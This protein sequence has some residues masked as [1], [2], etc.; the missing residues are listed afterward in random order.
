MTLQRY[1]APLFALALSAAPAVRAKQGRTLF[2]DSIRAV[3]AAPGNGPYVSSQA[4]LPGQSAATMVFSVSLKMRDLAGLQARLAAGQFVSQAEM[5]STYLPLASD[6]NRVA[7]WLT[8]QGLTTV[9]TDRNHTVL[10][11]EGTVSQVAQ[12]LGVTFSRVAVPDSA[13]SATEYTSAV[14]AP[15]LPSDLA[16]VVLGIN[17]LQPHLRFHH[18]PVT[19]LARARPQD[20]VGTGDYITPD[21]LASAY[22]MPVAWSTTAGSGQIIAIV[23][24]S[25]SP[26]ATQLN[27][28]NS[29]WSTVGSA[30]NT[31][32][33]A[34]VKV[35]GGGNNSSSDSETALDVEWAG[36]L[37]SGAKIRLYL[38]PDAVADPLP[39]I[40]S[41][42][43]TYPNISV[44][45]I[46]YGSDENQSEPGGDYIPRSEI[47][48]ISQ[49]IAQLAAA[50]VTVL[51]A[52]GDGGS[53]P[54][55]RTGY[56]SS[57]SLLSVE[58]PASDPNV[59]GVGGTTLG[60]NSGWAATG[61]VAW[62]QISSSPAL[63]SGGGI[64]TVFSAPSWQTGTPSSTARCVPDVAA[65]A[66]AT[67]VSRS[68]GAFIVLNSQDEDVIGTSLAC[69]TWAAVVAQVNQ[70][71][72]TAGLSTIGTPG[73][74]ASLYPLAGT[75]AFKDITT[76]TN[77]AYSAGVG[78]DLCTG[79]GSPNVTS[80][81]AALTGETPPTI[82]SEPQ[83]ETV[84]AGSSFS[85]SVTATGSSPLAYQWYLNGTAISGATGSSYSKSSSATTDAGSYTVVVSNAAG[86]ATSSAA[87]LT[88]DA[89]AVQ[90]AAPAAAASGGG[91]GG[92]APS[93]WFDGGLALLAAVRLRLR[94]RTLFKRSA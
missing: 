11:V 80:L 50:G 74:N 44:V 28:F 41:D 1:L 75:S 46:S 81:I 79:L 20:Q 36:A 12:A 45:S 61:E 31:G 54:D 13:G 63:A 70:A 83:S 40:L 33:L 25:P 65:A 34:V 60:F 90:T 76:G 69:P 18:T 30:Q 10:T 4:L 62:N 59:T 14:T 8:A 53:N 82:T 9:F 67:Y 55:P 27:D 73:L 5:A 26:N 21:D 24:E 85:F 29:F 56:Y 15:S 6:Y 71:R 87:T 84:T 16:G 66:A 89:A 19:P 94:A 86:S 43:Q 77:G 52:A 92:G 72:S 48:T 23:D 78:Y 3:P 17:R 93:L 37:A 88:V 49:E 39:Q 91:G 68:V 58:Y 22:A 51:A 32:N 64:S 2:P 7:A 35:D 57:S 47:Q 38:A 42:L